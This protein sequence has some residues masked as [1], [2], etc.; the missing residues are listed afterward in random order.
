[1]ML[2]DISILVFAQHY[3]PRMAVRKAEELGAKMGN[4]WPVSLDNWHTAQSSDAV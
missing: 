4:S 1:M 2:R 3:K